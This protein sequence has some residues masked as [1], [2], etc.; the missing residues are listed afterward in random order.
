M[1]PIQ[2]YHMTRVTFGD[3][4]LQCSTS[5]R[6]PTTFII[7]IQV[8]N[9]TSYLHFMWMTAWLVIGSHRTPLPAAEP[10]S[11]WRLRPEEVE[12]SSTQVT[13]SNE[14]SLHEPLEVKT[15][16]DDYPSQHQKTLGKVWNS[17]SDTLYIFIGDST[18]RVCT[19]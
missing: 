5:N 14:M 15:L 11:E 4:M 13:D 6:Q 8:Q 19:N 9:L 7:F 18:Q 12:S 2:D 17:R 16:T 10:S 3:L 1:S